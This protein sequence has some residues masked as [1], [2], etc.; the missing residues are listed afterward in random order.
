LSERESCAVGSVDQDDIIIGMSKPL[1]VTVRCHFD[2]RSLVPDEPVD[3]M[4]G[5]ALI[6]HLERDP[7]ASPTDGRSSLE[8]LFENAVNDESLPIDLSRQHDHY[9][10]RTP[11]KP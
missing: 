8:A 5:E 6:A 3:L 10:Y 9:L 7:L 4:T 1:V 2:G 11:K